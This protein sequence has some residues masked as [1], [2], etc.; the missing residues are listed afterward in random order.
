[1]TMQ[2][3]TALLLSL[4]LLGACAKSENASNAS[5]DST[6]RNLTLAPADS[7]AAMR[8]MPATPPAAPPSAASAIIEPTEMSIPPAMITNVTPT[9]MIA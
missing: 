3:T 2:Q 5:A 4:S 7:S 1:M 8:D 6:A 9:A